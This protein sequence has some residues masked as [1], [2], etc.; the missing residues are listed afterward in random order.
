[1][2]IDG[3]GGRADYNN[4]HILP[5]ELSVHYYR[6]QDTTSAALDLLALVRTIANLGS[7]E[8]GTE[9]DAIKSRSMWIVEA[10]CYNQWRKTSTFMM[11]WG[12]AMD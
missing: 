9:S 3:L 11:S 1:M 4:V 10:G 5:S 12:R 8:D 6:H 2:M 7:A